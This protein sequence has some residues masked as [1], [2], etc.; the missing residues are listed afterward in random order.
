MRVG[1]QQPSPQ[2][3]QLLAAAHL[4]QQVKMVAHPTK[5]VEASV[6]ALAIT[7]E[8]M[9][10]VATVVVAGEHGLAVVAAVGQVVASGF[11][12]LFAAWS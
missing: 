4:Q 3:R 12:P 1:T 6:V 2:G 9:Q 5:M 11:G 7:V 10:K 8:P